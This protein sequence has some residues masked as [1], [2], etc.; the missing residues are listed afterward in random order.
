M[1]RKVHPVLKFYMPGCIKKKSSG[2]QVF[3]LCHQVLQICWSGALRC[4][5]PTFQM[6]KSISNDLRG[7]IALVVMAPKPRVLGLLVLI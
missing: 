2:P 3:K 4:V 6:R 7:A 1:R 5:F